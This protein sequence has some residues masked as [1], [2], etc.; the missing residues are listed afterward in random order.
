[1]VKEA[2]TNA[3]KGQLLY[4]VFFPKRTAPPA[5]RTNIIGTQ[6]KWEYTSTTNKQIHR[7]IKQMK[8]WKAT[9]SGTIP[10][11]VF[12]HVQELLVPF[13]GPI[14]RATDSLKMY[15]EDWKLTEMPILKKPGKLSGQPAK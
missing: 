3:E 4:Q 1:M 8:P 15:P 2:H 5:E 6:A 12:V 11:A 7:A 9:R 14:F 13:L 10:N